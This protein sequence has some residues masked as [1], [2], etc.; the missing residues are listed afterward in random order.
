MVAMF[1]NSIFLSID[2]QPVNDEGE[3]IIFQLPDKSDPYNIPF[4][5][6][7]LKGL[8]SKVNLP[9]ILKRVELGNTF[10]R[11][12]LIILSLKG[13][14]YVFSIWFLPWSIRCI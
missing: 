8:M 11:K 10:D 12:F 14:L 2:G 6:I 9:T 3:N 13:L 7:Y 4:L 1:F 5:N